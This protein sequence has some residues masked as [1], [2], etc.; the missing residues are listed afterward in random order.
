[1]M[2]VAQLNDKFGGEDL[3]FPKDNRALVEPSV[4]IT[5]SIALIL[6]VCSKLS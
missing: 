6:T 3:L 2:F 1:M 4:T 5:I